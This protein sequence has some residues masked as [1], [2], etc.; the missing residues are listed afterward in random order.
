MRPAAS[1]LRRR[2]P[3]NDASLP[4]ENSAMPSWRGEF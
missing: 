1:L 3:G 4:A 2:N